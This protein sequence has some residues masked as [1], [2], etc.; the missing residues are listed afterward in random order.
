[1]LAQTNV[2]RSSAVGDVLMPAMS[3]IVK[4]PFRLP[5]LAMPW[6]RQPSFRNDRSERARISKRSTPVTFAAPQL[7][8]H[9]SS[10]AQTS[11]LSIS[12]P[13]PTHRP[14]SPAKQ[15]AERH[16]AIRAATNYQE[17]EKV[18]RACHARASQPYPYTVASTLFQIG[19]FRK[20]GLFADAQAGRFVYSVVR[21]AAACRRYRLDE[22]T[23]TLKGVTSAGLRSKE[24]DA[25]LIRD[26]QEVC[27]G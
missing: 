6:K 27:I 17:L 21:D 23:L 12:Q 3:D 18:Y 5:S 20:Q 14:S 10:D 16:M 15:L 25:A 1:M 2:Q 24:M 13:S 26:A 22:L 8:Q 11:Q 19:G 9:S 4:L 7:Q